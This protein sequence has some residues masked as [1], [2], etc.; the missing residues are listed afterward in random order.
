MRANV[1]AETRLSKRAL[2]K[3][4]KGDWATLLDLRSDASDKRLLHSLYLR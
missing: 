4:R 2:H 3:S 1:V